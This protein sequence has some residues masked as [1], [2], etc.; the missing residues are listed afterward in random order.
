M[1]TRKPG[2][3]TPTVMQDTKTHP[4]LE[5]MERARIWED[6]IEDVYVSV[7]YGFPWSDVP[8]VGATVM[9]ITNNDQALADEIADDMSK[10]IWKV[11]EEFANK[12]YPRPDEAVPQIKEA[13]AAGQTP[14]IVGDYSD[15][16]GD[17]T[18]ILRALMTQGASNFVIAT[19]KDPTLLESLSDEGKQSGDEVAVEI[20]GYLAESSGS[21]V[22][23]EGTLEYFGPYQN[24]KDGNEFDKMGV[25]RFGNN[26]RIIISPDLYQVTYPAIFDVL[27]I[28]QTALDIIVLKSRVHFRRGFDLIDYAC[29]IFIVDAPEPYFGTVHLDALEYEHIPANLYP[30]NS[31]TKRAE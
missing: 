31:S 4:S 22:R 11:R 7:L 12:H 10:Y 26:N 9:V 1:A 27:E 30:L 6:H 19:L 29:S 28:D 3:I 24:P 5:I 13:V 16:M 15:R 25:I 21:P 14:V 8:D 23:L 17:A 18:H 20:G 2:V